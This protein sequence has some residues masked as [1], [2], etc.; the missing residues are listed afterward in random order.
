MRQPASGVSGI[1]PA[2]PRLHFSAPAP[3]LLVTVTAQRM[4]WARWWG[5]SPTSAHVV[6]TGH[7][8][9][10]IVFL[11][12]HLVI[13]QWSGEIFTVV[14]LARTRGLELFRDGRLISSCCEGLP[15][16]KGAGIENFKV[17]NRGGYSC[18]RSGT[19][20][21]AVSSLLVCSSLLPLSADQQSLLQ[22]GHGVQCCPGPR[23]DLASPFKCPNADRVIVLCPF[24]PSL[25][26][27]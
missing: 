7:V 24:T 14:Y 3:A 4:G 10:G 1:W 23:P 6:V 9:V 27:F 13:L 20:W 21:C 22:Y 19:A 18:H 25:T 15:H 11:V 12:V 16:V 8:T 17:R 5:L 2:V 26:L